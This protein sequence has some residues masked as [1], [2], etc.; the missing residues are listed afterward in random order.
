MSED[1]VVIASGVRTPVGAYMGGLRS[2]EAYD[3]TVGAV[4]AD[5]VLPV[6]LKETND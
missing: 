2:V 6:Y 4:A 5:W 1:G 3:L